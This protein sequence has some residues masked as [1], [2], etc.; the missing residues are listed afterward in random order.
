MLCAVDYILNLLRAFSAL[1]PMK[2]FVFF[3]AFRAAGSLQIKPSGSWD[4]NGEAWEQFEH[5]QT[6]A[7]FVFSLSS[8]A[9]KAWEACARN[10]LT[11]HFTDFFTDFE[12]KKKHDCFAVYHETF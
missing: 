3:V 12:K 1:Q 2:K 9:R 10:T 11:P 5:A 6:K 7:I 8:H 4:E